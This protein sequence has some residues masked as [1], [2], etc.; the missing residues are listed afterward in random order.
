MQTR[1]SASA[2]SDRYGTAMAAAS[3]WWTI[4]MPCW[5]SRRQKNT[6]G[7]AAT[8]SANGSGQGGVLSRLIV[9][10]S[11]LS[12]GCRC[13]DAILPFKFSLASVTLQ[14]A[15]YDVSVLSG[16]YLSV[17]LFL[18]PS[19]FSSPSL[20]FPLPPFLPS[21]RRVYVILSLLL[22]LLLLRLLSLTLPVPLSIH[23]CYPFS[24]NPLPRVIFDSP[25]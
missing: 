22:S 12:S 21:Y 6:F 18:R 4:S 1:G 2:Q 8:C 9:G 25:E 19:P 23:I 5:N 20:P 24:M 13:V 14:L 3:R 7:H 15:S 17:S 10:P 11:F 16:F